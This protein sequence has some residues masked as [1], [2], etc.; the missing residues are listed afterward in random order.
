MCI[1]APVSALAG[2]PCDCADGDVEDNEHSL[3]WASV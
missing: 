2:K 1:I 3:Y